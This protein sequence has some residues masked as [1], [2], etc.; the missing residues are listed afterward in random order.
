M[1]SIILFFA[2]ASAMPRSIT[3]EDFEAIG[4]DFESAAAGY[5]LDDK[6]STQL[7]RF[8]K[9][10]GMAKTLVFTM[11]S[12]YHE[13]V[14]SVD[15]QVSRNRLNIS[16]YNVKSNNISKS[17]AF[18]EPV[19]G[20]QKPAITELIHRMVERPKATVDFRMME[21]V[22]MEVMPVFSS[23]SYNENIAENSVALRFMSYETT[24]ALL[25]MSFEEQKIAE[26]PDRFDFT[27]NV[28]YNI[29]VKNNQPDR[30]EFAL[31]VF[32]DENLG[33]LRNALKATSNINDYFNN[34]CTVASI[35]MEAMTSIGFKEVKKIEED[36][37]EGK[38]KYQLTVMMKFYKTNLITRLSYDP[39]KGPVGT[40]TAST[41]RVLSATD[42]ELVLENKELS[43]LE[44]TRHLKKDLLELFKQN[45]VVDQLNLFYIDILN[46]F[47]EVYG[48]TY[49]IGYSDLKLDENV[50]V[51]NGDNILGFRL[52]NNRT[53]DMTVTANSPQGF[54]GCKFMYT[55]KNGSIVMQFSDGYAQD[56]SEYSFNLN[57]FD[58]ATV[59]EYIE[60]IV[61]SSYNSG[62]MVKA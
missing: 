57:D 34:L 38:G 32:N 26:N 33:A 41:R 29:S 27:I 56:H 21:D 23:L 62:I 20:I 9:D 14:A 11:D 25:S 51:N 42:D 48:Y 17:I 53:V 54:E 28:E 37:E 16:I 4:K 19:F 59:A 18:N 45:N 22:M 15:L 46:K 6:L 36:T 52:N 2:I 3:R 24:V 30:H 13:H 35:Y 1:K 8:K 49:G 12:R 43:N 55:E 40:Y 10:S 61:A 31:K 44:F 58:F 39:A 5:R 60:V 7:S 47:K 50:K